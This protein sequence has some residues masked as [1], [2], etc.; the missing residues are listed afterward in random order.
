MRSSWNGYGFAGPLKRTYGTGLSPTV[1]A[2]PRQCADPTAPLK[3][4]IPHA[5]P[6]PGTI[7]IT[8]RT[9]RG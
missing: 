2:A 3:G 7:A 4:V 9:S 6:L 5:D 1:H 8:A